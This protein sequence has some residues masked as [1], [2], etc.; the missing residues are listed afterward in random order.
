PRK[1]TSTPVRTCAGPAAGWATCCG[2]TSHTSGKPARG[3][4]GASAT[5]VVA[6]G[7]PVPAQPW[8][9]FSTGPAGPVE[10]RTHNIPRRP[11]P[12]EYDAPGY[13]RRQTAMSTTS[14]RQR[15]AWKA[16]EAHYQNVK[17]LHLRRLFADDP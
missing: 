9:R 5:G 7:L 13:L 16:L 8:V 14:L 11:A 17:E 15:P 4:R 3:G 10:N 1:A 2:T 12:G 6:R